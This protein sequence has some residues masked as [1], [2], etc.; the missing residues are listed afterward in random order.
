[1]K[2]YPNPVS[3]LITIKVE[4]LKDDLQ[5]MLYSVE[6]K[7]VAHHKI[8]ALETKLDIAHLAK[9][10]YFLSITAQNEMVKTYKILKQ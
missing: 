4:E 5:L 7:Q 8:T 2:V 6:G 3:E 9:G 10:S 1:M